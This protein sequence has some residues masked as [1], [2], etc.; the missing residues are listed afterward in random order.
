VPLLLAITMIALVIHRPWGG[1]FFAGVAIISGLTMVYQQK[2]LTKDDWRGV[3]HYIESHMEDGDLVYGNPAASSLA[4]DLYWTKPLPFTGY[5]FNYDIL[6][7]GWAGQ[8]LTPGLIDKQLSTS[9]QGF[10][11]VW[12]L[13]FFPQFW[14]MNGFISSWLAAHSVLM[15]DRTFGNIHVR[16]Y[17][18]TP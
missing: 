18:L 9:T 11:R 3:A 16:L 15:D 4:L 6:H 1:L 2:I 17:E 14:D 12:L 10:K 8:T 13:E 5:P 7:G